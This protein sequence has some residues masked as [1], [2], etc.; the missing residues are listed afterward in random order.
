MIAAIFDIHVHLHVHTV[1]AHAQQSIKTPYSL[2][3][4]CFDVEMHTQ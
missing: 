2:G 3:Y 4:E 1:L